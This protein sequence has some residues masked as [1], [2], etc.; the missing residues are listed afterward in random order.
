MLGC[1]FPLAALAAAV[2]IIL[3]A[4]SQQELSQEK[5]HVQIGGVALSSVRSAKNRVQTLS[6][7]TILRYT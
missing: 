7:N 6:G 2:G 3:G 1:R 4:L 5:Q